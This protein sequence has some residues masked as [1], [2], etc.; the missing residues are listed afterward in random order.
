[1]KRPFSYQWLPSNIE[2]SI[3]FSWVL[4]VPPITVTR[5]V[6]GTSAGSA[7]EYQLITEFRL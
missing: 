6:D 4:P 3:F 7:N 1:V 2:A 5:I